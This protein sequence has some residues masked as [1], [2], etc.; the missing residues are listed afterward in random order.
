MKFLIGLLFLVSWFDL[1]SCT[2]YLVTKGASKDGSTMISYAAD[3]H[4]RYGELYYRKGG[5]HPDGSTVKIFDRG[6]NKLLGEIP[7]LSYTYSVVGFMNENQ[8]SIGES[9]FGGRNELKDT[10]GLLD[11]GSLMF[12][13]MQRSKTAREAIKIITDLVEKYGYYSSGESFSIADPNEVWIME[14]IGKGTNLQYDKRLKKYVNND[15]GAVWVAIRIPDGYVSAHANHAR[16]TTFPFQKENNWDNIN[17]EVYHSPDV[18]SFARRKAWFDGD[19]KDFSFSDAYAPL[20][21]GAARFCE[22]RVWSMFKEISD[23]MEQYKDYAA[24]YVKSPRMPLYIKPNRKLDVHDLVSFKRD[25]MQGTEFDMTKDVGAGPFAMPY[26]WRPLTWK[27]NDKTYFHERVTLTQQTGFSYI[28][29]ARSW[30]PNHIGGIIWFGVDDAGCSVHVPFYCGITSIPEPYAEGNGTMTKYS[31][32]SAFWLFNRVANFT[33]SQYNNIIIDVNKAQTE[34]EEKFRT[35]IP[36]FDE[37]AQ[38]L[39]K[40][41]PDLARSFLTYNSNMLAT[42]TIEKWN[43]LNNFLLVKYID[44]NIKYEENG[45]F[46]ENGHGYPVP[47]KHVGYPEWWFEYIIKE[48]DTKFEYKD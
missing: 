38:N 34:L 14:L 3:S 7:Q 24:G 44:G 28:T 32:T 48:T 26:R 37:A 17:Q 16:I 22:L 45:I 6:T 36:I 42:M 29:Q 33:Y 13:A 8:V 39:H 40:T 4:I 27:I 20:D 35:Y 41:N 10:T 12:I 2:S 5:N 47:P 19:D 9:T 15:K 46:L 21:F 31:P 43:E 1:F 25:Y 11:Y 18:I 30:L 23:D